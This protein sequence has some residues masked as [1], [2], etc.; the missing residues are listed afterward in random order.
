[1]AVC[2]AFSGYLGDADTEAWKQYDAVELLRQYS[3][4][5]QA[6]L[7]DT[8]TADNFYQVRRRH[9]SSATFVAPLC[10][11]LCNPP[12]TPGARL[13]TLTGALLL[14]VLERHLNG[15][16]SANIC[17]RRVAALAKSEPPAAAQLVCA[18]TALKSKEHGAVCGGR[19]G[20]ARPSAGGVSVQEK[21]LQPEALQEA[22][23][24]GGL[25]LELRLHPGYDHSYYFIATFLPEHVRFHAK[26]LSAI[27]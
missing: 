19:E 3:G 24:G 11:P 21:Q 18:L 7:V 25:D 1:M 20:W 17:Q 14:G 22:N 23:G 8:G 5:K 12:Y 4:P 2:A 27:A 13:C 10:T 16:A 26:H 15:I 6:C 9:P